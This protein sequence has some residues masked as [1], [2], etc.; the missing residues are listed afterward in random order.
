MGHAARLGRMFK[1]LV[2][3]LLGLLVLGLAQPWLRRLG[4]GSL[5][6]DLHFTRKGQVYYLPISST[7]ILS[8]L[9]SLIV[10]LLR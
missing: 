10:Q 1:W 5:P 2:T 6:G 8:L 9:L 3:I 7:L 4:L